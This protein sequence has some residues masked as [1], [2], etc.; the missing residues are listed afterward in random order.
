MSID[1]ETPSQPQPVPQP[2]RNNGKV[3]GGAILLVI[4]TVFLLQQLHIF[5][6][7]HWLF[8]WPTWLIIWG[9][10]VGARHNFRN[11]GWLIMVLIGMVFLAHDAIPGF[12][13]WAFAWPVAII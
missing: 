12:D 13:A 3:I 8:N 9:L 6:L 5:Y 1:I 10:Y 4:G 11:S 2:P 7:A